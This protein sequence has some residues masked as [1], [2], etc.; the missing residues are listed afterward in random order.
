M[1]INPIGILVSP[2]KQWEAFA[3]TPANAFSGFLPYLLIMAALPSAAWYYGTTQ[4][5][6]QVGDGEITHL[7]SNSALW[8]ATAMYIAVVLSIIA[9]GYSIHWMS[10]T[11]GS[12]ESS[13][14]KGI[15]FASLTATP[16][17]LLGLSGIYPLFWID[18]I[19]SLIGISWSTYLLYTGIPAAMKIPEERGF[20]YASALLAVALVIFMVLLGATTILWDMGIIPVFAD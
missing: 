17:F 11:Y 7:T 15:A 6:W 10:E 9:I 8:I 1:L 18:M 14:M 16:F 5:G 4:I 12:A 3:N 13:T 2:R 20:M 19:L